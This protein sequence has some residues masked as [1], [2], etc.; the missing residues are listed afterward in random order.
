MK[1][2]LAYSY[3]CN[4]RN[5]KKRGQTESFPIPCK[6]PITP[7][8]TPSM[9]A[10]V[11]LKH[12]DVPLTSPATDS[13]VNCIRLHPDRPYTIGRSPR[14][15]NFV[16]EDRRV[17][18]QHCQVFYDSF[19]R[20][21]YIVDGTLIS[22]PQFRS[23][24]E[25]SGSVARAS[26]NGV[27]VNGIRVRIGAAVELTD[28]DQ[29]SFA[30]STENSCRNPV[31]I[32]FVIHKIVFEEMQ[33]FNNSQ[34]P[35]I[36]SCPKGC[37]RIFASRADGSLSSLI[38]R[39]NFLLS[40]CRRILHSD[41][42]ISYIRTRCRYSFGNGFITNNVIR[43]PSSDIGRSG[44]KRKG[45]ML[46]ETSH[47]HCNVK[48]KM[49]STSVMHHC[50]RVV[51]S[52]SSSDLA[53]LCVQGD[54]SHLQDNEVQVP[55]DTRAA[56]GN[57]GTSSFNFTSRDNLPRVGGVVKNKAC[58]KNIGSQPGKNFYLNR[59][60]FVDQ[61]SSSHH[62]VISL[63]ELL[64]PVQSITQI[65]IATFTSDILW[66]LSSCEIPSHLP[67]TVAC[68]NTERCWSSSTDNR[69]SA[70]YP[71]FPNLIVVY[72]PF[73]EAI[74]FGEDL[75]RHG[76]GCHH[77][78]L[79]VLQRDD[80]IRVIITSAN[81]VPTQWNAVT[82]TIWWQDFP[83]RS[84]PDYSSLFTQFHSGEVNQDSKSDFASYLAGFI[85]TLLTD[86][87]SQAQWIVELAKYDFGGAMGHLVASVPGIHSY[88][89]PYIMESRHSVGVSVFSLHLFG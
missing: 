74:A 37:K 72:P 84:A 75:K 78:K 58:S 43:A 77:P 4:T 59:L 12:L 79:F 63:P 88:K 16:F 36:V 82:N 17:G 19:H 62:S 45:S 9:T 10:L 50:E 18:S 27:F 76:I 24:P 61:S 47:V 22:I 5:K 8:G 6:R 11:E 51:A 44:V 81:L 80:S 14:R 3:G 33:R 56:D 60:A 73:P 2:S 31:R 89:A 28:G 39:A 1:D 30:C 69:T 21:L 71:E 65:L 25:E 15:C 55:S 48:N 52:E 86:V 38:S 64:H 35:V 7:R 20:K 67:I 54:A 26:L 46:C 83:R 13:P 32:G 41:D 42:P 40:E 49:Q 29:V 34:G 70:P 23:Q 53:A 57:P 87:P 66:F 68:H 85:A